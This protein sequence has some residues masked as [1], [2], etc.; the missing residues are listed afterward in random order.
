MFLFLFPESYNMIYYNSL[1]SNAETSGQSCNDYDS[2]VVITKSE[3]GTGV[4]NMVPS[5]E[6]VEQKC[7]IYT[8]EGAYI[9]LGNF[10]GT[11]VS[12]P[13]VCA[14]HSVTWSL[15]LKINSSTSFTSNRYFVS[16]GGRTWRGRGITFLYR[17]S[18]NKFLFGARSESW[19]YYLKYETNKIPM[20]RWFHLAATVDLSPTKSLVLYLDGKEF[21]RCY[22]PTEIT[23][24]NDGCT[25]LILGNAN[26]CFGIIPSSLTSGGSAAY[27]NL[28]VFDHL[29]S[30]EQIANLYAC[31]SLDWA[32]RIRSLYID[33]TFKYS[34]SLRYVCTASASTG[35]TI[36][37]SVYHQE[38]AQWQ[39]LGRNSTEEGC[40][41]TPTSF[42]PCVVQSALVI[43][44]G[45]GPI[46]EG[47][48]ITCTANSGARNASVSIRQGQVL[49]ATVGLYSSHGNAGLFV[50]K[51][52]QEYYG[53]FD[54]SGEDLENGRYPFVCT[55]S[56]RDM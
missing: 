54:R 2:P 4:Y 13:D 49:E 29:L 31:G 15:W 17:N 12:D 8:G 26:P 20:D 41:I 34:G 43:D 46:A 22:D 16:V 11:C 18:D 10:A 38:R 52:G 48:I 9:N 55:K 50:A 6:V 3:I 42:S 5:P 19:T 32:L 28:M 36:Y 35:P 40:E 37:W 30:K 33:T 25:K 27:S 21:G 56:R 14:S 47:D 44:Q 1:G 7:S 24:P 53:S 39:D 23:S 51:T 45:H